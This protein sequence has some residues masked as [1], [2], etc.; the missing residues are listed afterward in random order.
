MRSSQSVYTS[1]EDITGLRIDV[2]EP[3]LKSYDL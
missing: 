3:E 2:F 1:D